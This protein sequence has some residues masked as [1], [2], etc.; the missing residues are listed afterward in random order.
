[1]SSQNDLLPA[2]NE[3]TAKKAILDFVARV[4]KEGGADFVPVNERIAV[5]DNDGT[6]WCE[7]PVPNQAFFADDRL[8]ALAPRHPEW[9][10]TEPFKSALHIEAPTNIKRASQ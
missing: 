8:K 6:L 3:G 1:M 10:T 9:Q 2:W 4:T 7:M 5:F